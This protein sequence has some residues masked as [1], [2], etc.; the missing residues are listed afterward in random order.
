MIRA[1]DAFPE[2]RNIIHAVAEGIGFLTKLLQ[3]LQNR[4]VEHG[5]L[6][7][8]ELQIRQ[9]LC[10]R[11]DRLRKPHSRLTIDGLTFLLVVRFVHNDAHLFIPGLIVHHLHLISGGTNQNRLDGESSFLHSGARILLKQHT[12]QHGGG[13]DLKRH[14][15][16]QKFFPTQ[17][18]Q[19]FR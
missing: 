12:I 7:H 10:R 2:P 3:S 8:L 1:P 13:D 16:F 9:I 11:A 6:D 5:D 19:L 15:V 4:S 14:D 17:S 18:H